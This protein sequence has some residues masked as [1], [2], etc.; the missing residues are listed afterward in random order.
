MQALL[1]Q[2]LERAQLLWNRRRELQLDR[3]P[4]DLWTELNPFPEDSEG[5]TTSMRLYH[6]LS[7]AVET[8]ACHHA[9]HSIRWLLDRLDDE[10]CRRLFAPDLCANVHPL[11]TALETN[12]LLSANCVWDRMLRLGI[13]APRE[14]VT[15]PGER[16]CF[17]GGN[18]VHRLARKDC[19]QSVVF[20]VERLEL[21]FDRIKDDG[22]TPLHVAVLNQRSDTAMYL[23]WLGADL[24]LV[25]TH[26][27]IES[28]KG[29]P[30]DFALDSERKSKIGLHALRA[31]DPFRL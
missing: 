23:A 25:A 15:L 31:I 28:F 22:M 6:N 19:Y 3:L 13:P 12:D 21:P 9:H 5:E 30:H 10:A 4:E 29:T 27:K 17:D 11:L 2:D 14:Y 24:N 8:L 18:W 7:N 20:A 26:P 16:T 1:V